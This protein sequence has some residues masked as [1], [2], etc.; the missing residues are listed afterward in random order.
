MEADNQISALT[1]GLLEL[2]SATSDL[3][4]QN[5][6]VGNLSSDRRP[7][8]SELLESLMRAAHSLKGAARIVNLTVVVQISHALEDCFVAVQQ[9]ALVFRGEHVDLLLQ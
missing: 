4:I 6:E 7:P 3:G 2:E 1:N 5:P 8:K 9:G